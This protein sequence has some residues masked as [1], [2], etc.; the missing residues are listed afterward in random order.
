MYFVDCEKIEVMFVF[1][2]EY[3]CLFVEYLS[4]NIEIEKKVLE[5]IV[6]FLIENVLDVGNVMIDGFIMRDFG[7]YDDII[8]ILVDE[9]VVKKEEEMLL[10]EIV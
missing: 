1:F 5:R 3:I 8:D 7:S 9:K 2:D 4:W 10:K 6:Y